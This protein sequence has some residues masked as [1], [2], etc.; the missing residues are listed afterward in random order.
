MRPAVQS[1]I[2]TLTFQPCYILCT[3]DTRPQARIAIMIYP[4]LP[5]VSAHARHERHSL[6]INQVL[7]ILLLLPRV[8]PCI[9]AS[10]LLLLGLSFPTSGIVLIKHLGRD[11]V[12]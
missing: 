1:N 6:Y 3:L 4:I 8:V 2:T 5:Q 7:I 10:L 9:L 12:E 11:A